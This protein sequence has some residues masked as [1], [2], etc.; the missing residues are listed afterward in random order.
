MSETALHATSLFAQVGNPPSGENLKAI[1]LELLVSDPDSLR[2]LL[3]KEEGRERNEYA[4]A[5]LRIGLLSLRHARGQISTPKPWKRARRTPSRRLEACRLSSLA[6]RKSAWRPYVGAQGVLRPV[7]RQVSGARGSPDQARWGTGT[8]RVS[9]S[10][11]SVRMA[12]NWPLRS[13]PTSAA[14]APL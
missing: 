1:L 10:A 11:R 9:P 13:Q 6:W 3:Q 12:P 5:A 4:L 2:E 8:N 14:I 7:E